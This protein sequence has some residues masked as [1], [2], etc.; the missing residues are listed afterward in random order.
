MA[1]VSSNLESTAAGLRC[2]AASDVGMRRSSNQDSFAVALAENPDDW[3]RQGHLFV[4]ADGMG[5]HAAGELASQL[6][7]DS[8]PH[9]YHKQTDLS[10]NEAIEKAMQAANAEIYCKGETSIDFRG[11][12]TTCS[13]LLLLPDGALAAHV[14]DSRIYRLRNNQF[15][16]LTF[17]HSLVWE[18][19]KA[20]N[21]TEED[22]PSFVPKNVIT[23]SLGPHS[24]MS[25]D[26]EG[27]F[28]L[29][30]GDRFLLCS[31]G[32]TGP[33]SSELIGMV[34][35]AMPPDEATQTLIDLAN[36][37]GGPDNITVIV[38][39]V[40]EVR[41]LPNIDSGN[42]LQ[43]KTNGNKTSDFVRQNGNWLGGVALSLILWIAAIVLGMAGQC[44]GAAGMGCAA[45]M[46][47]GWVVLALLR[48][49]SQATEKNRVHGRHGKGPYRSYACQPNAENIQTLSDT[50]QQLEELEKKRDWDF[51]W[52]PIRDDRH[53]AQQSVDQGDFPKAVALFCSA[54]RRLMV[55]IREKH[56]PPPSDSDVNLV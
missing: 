23:R 14:G 28:P 53:A 56:L 5:A 12:G 38:A 25:V 2:S 13:C 42:A 43:Q 16:Q 35:G 1:N 47:D 20:S 19:A 18:M 36:L 37:L 9:S 22:I 40:V 45:L 15:E 31:D 54:V 52:Q 33:L 21:A 11:M 49:K 24:K 27:P 48:A 34:L 41:D 30:T 39:E 17:D 10:P 50:V 26:I 6:A 55:E 7:T 8:I 46:A 4:V 51:D 29:Q 44:W 32:L 3:L